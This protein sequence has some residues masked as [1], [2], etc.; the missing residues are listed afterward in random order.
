ML[1][2]GVATEAATIMAVKLAK[3]A[4]FLLAGRPDRLEACGGA[5][6]RA[7]ERGIRRKSLSRQVLSGPAAG[8]M[9]SPAK[10]HY[11]RRAETALYG[12][13][14]AGRPRH[15][16]CAGKMPAPPRCPRHGLGRLLGQASIVKH[17]TPVDQPVVP[18][19]RGG[20]RP[21]CRGRLRSGSSC[22][23]RCCGRR[24]VASGTACRTFPARSA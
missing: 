22:R 5:V 24:T 3:R 21:C 11:S 20:G 13:A 23:R 7:S 18:V 6:P 10:R 15:G 1:H 2:T 16:A 8:D 17:A 12:C 19:A 9:L 14:W 4:I